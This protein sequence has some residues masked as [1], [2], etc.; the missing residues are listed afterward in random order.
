MMADG[1]MDRVERLKTD[2]VARSEQRHR[3]CVHRCSNVHR[4]RV[5]CNE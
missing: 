3:R 4:S 2:M 1:R 5:I